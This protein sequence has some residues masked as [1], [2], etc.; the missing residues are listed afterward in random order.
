MTTTHWV[1]VG[2]LDVES[3]DGRTL[4]DVT[5]PDRVPVR[6]PEPPA[7]EWELSDGSGSID[8]RTTC[9]LRVSEGW[10]EALLPITWGEHA[11]I[12]LGP[13]TIERHGDVADDGCPI[14]LSG[15]VAYVMV[16]PG[17]GHAWTGQPWSES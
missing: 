14:V 16:G 12:G 7:Y 8:E 13:V 17:M 9:A 3:N 5:V 6:S 2:R 11:S 10:I 1:A 4:R 15:T